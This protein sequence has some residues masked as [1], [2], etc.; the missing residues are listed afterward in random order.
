MWIGWQVLFS[1]ITMEARTTPILLPVHLVVC[2][3]SYLFTYINHSKDIICLLS[4]FYHRLLKM[5][6]LRG[7]FNVCLD[8]C[9]LSAGLRIWKD[10]FKTFLRR[11][12][13]SNFYSSAK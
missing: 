2:I 12:K 4:K 13:E 3:L 7:Q 11:E 6:V 1:A 5:D 9:R 10:F 8:F